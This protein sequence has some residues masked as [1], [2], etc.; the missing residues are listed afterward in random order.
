MQKQKFL[1]LCRA[2]L[3]YAISNVT[4]RQQALRC[5]TLYCVVWPSIV[6]VFHWT[7]E[8]LVAWQEL[9]KRRGSWGG[10]SMLVKDTYILKCGKMLSLKNF[11]LPLFLYL[12]SEKRRLQCRYDT[13]N[14]R[15]VHLVNG[16]FFLKCSN[17]IQL[18]P[19]QVFN[20]SLHM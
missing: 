20:R 14:K 4:K 13:L 18:L 7:A 19:W 11:N 15:I 1:S 16:K 3:G 12:E 6:F 5:I 9:N 10:G 8:R 2:V 17:D